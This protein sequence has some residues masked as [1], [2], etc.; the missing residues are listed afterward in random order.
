MA[1]VT[2]DIVHSSSV[3]LI[4]FLHHLVVALEFFLSDV[5]YNIFVSFHES[6]VVNTYSVRPSKVM[7]LPV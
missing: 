7:N 5:K 1:V 2:A 6:E 4:S 3:D